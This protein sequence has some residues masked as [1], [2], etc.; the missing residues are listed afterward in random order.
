M[1]EFIYDKKIKNKTKQIKKITYIYA[2]Y[3]N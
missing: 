1:Y 3:L 2:V